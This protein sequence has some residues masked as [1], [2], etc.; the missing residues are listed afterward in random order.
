[1][2]KSSSNAAFVSCHKIWSESKCFS[3]CNV[4]VQGSGAKV[5]LQ[6]QA[7]CGH[8]CF[9]PTKGCVQNQMKDITSMKAPQ[10]L[11]VGLQFSRTFSISP[12]ESHSCC[13]LSRGCYNGFDFARRGCGKSVFWWRNWMGPKRSDFRV[14]FCPRLPVWP[15]ERHLTV[16]VCPQSHI[17]TITSFL[18]PN[19]TFSKG[20]WRMSSQSA[21]HILHKVAPAKSTGILEQNTFSPWYKNHILPT[22]LNNTQS[23]NYSGM[24]CSQLFW[25]YLSWLI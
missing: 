21:P 5:R 3:S 19:W 18:V 1:M 23:C 4:K 16:R 8:H 7:G 15:W 17:T 14:Y 9:K 10:G 22:W 24:N 13:Y 20:G 6:T 11:T 25:E 12:K 2:I